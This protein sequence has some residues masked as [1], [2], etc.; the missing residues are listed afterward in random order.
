MVIE[1]TGVKDGNV[2]KD[3]IVAKDVN[4]PNVVNHGLK[5]QKTIRKP[6]VRNNGYEVIY[7]PEP[8]SVPGFFIGVCRGGIAPVLRF[9]AK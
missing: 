8:A 7:R 3:T 4:V 2:R 5:E 9:P 6:V 1:M